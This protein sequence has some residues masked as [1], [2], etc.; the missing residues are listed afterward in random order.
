MMLT[1]VALYL[2]CRYACGFSD[3]SLALRFERTV[4]SVSDVWSLSCIGESI[5]LAESPRLLTES[6]IDISALLLA[7]CACDVFGLVS[8]D[9]GRF[10]SNVLFFLAARFDALAVLNVNELSAAA[11]SCQR[12]Y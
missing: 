7:S 3:M 12:Q 10:P 2:F 11:D 4:I 9:I 1:E 5:T 6:T 8:G